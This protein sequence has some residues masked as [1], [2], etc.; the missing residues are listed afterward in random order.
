MVSAGESGMLLC[1]GVMMES[2]G[3]QA[4]GIS[5]PSRER[6]VGQVKQRLHDYCLAHFPFQVE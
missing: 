3:Y 6:F 1:V 4:V 5:H 2:C